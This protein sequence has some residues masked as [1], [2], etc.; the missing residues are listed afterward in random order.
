MQ[1]DPTQSGYHQFSVS[2][3]S[4]YIDGVS[5]TSSIYDYTSINFIQQNV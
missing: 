5:F 4:V 1:Y 3:E 2:Y